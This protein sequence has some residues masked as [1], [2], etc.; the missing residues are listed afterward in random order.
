MID[1]VRDGPKR[2]IYAPRA[3]ARHFKLVPSVVIFGR[4]GGRDD[5]VTFYFGRMKFFEREVIFGGLFEGND[6]LV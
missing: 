6:R 2:D 4:T 5:F 3:R 1:E